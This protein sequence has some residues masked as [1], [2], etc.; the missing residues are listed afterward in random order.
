[1]ASHSFINIRPLGEESSSSAATPMSFRIKGFICS[2]HVVRSSVSGSGN[3]WHC[4]QIFVASER[5][6]T[7]LKLSSETAC[8]RTAQTK[9]QKANAKAEFEHSR[10]MGLAA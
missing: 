8:A 2:R 10:F 5:A 9:S 7:N 1:M 6:R 4:E 3:R